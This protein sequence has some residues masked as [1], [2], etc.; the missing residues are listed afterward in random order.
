MHLG[1]IR[2]ILLQRPSAGDRWRHFARG[3]DFRR[4]EF[5]E[6][7][8][9]SCNGTISQL[10]DKLKMKLQPTANYVFG[11]G[12]ISDAIANSIAVYYIDKGL[13]E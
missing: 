9:F 6:N 4:P 1:V 2:H 8:H 12:D 13:D 10:L 7:Q 3:N 5:E 11:V